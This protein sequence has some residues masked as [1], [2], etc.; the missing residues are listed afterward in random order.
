MDIFGA[1]ARKTNARL[2]ELLQEQDTTA[3]ILVRRDLEL[4][5]ANERLRDLDEI[6]SQFVSVAA[7]QLR[8]PLTG[9]KWTLNALLEEGLGRLNREQR[10]FAKDAYESTL[11]LIDLINDLLDASRLEEGRFGFK[12]KRQAFVPLVKKACETFKKAAA[13]KGVAFPLHLPKGAIPQLDFD[14]ERMRIVL[15]NLLDNAI[16]Y[17][18]PG[19]SVTVK[20]WQEKGKVIVEVA[21][22]GIGMAEDQISKVFT[23]FFRAENAQLY[24][25]SGTGLGLYLVKNIVEHHG[26]AIFFTTKENKGSAFTFT[27]PIPKSDT[28]KV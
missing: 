19:G 6:K 27:L 3:K 28:K 24:Q 2:K 18:L 14:E 4:T 21:D 16:K 11:R 10:K 9:I 5:R 8:T 13:E 15:E 25:T 26:G 20:L 12:K 23:K 7:H 1:Q 17:T 22:T